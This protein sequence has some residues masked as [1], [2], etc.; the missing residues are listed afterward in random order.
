[1]ANEMGLT[2]KSGKQLSK[3]CIITMLKNPF[4]YGNML[5][6]EEEYEGNHEPIINKTLFDKVQEALKLRNKPLKRKKDQF[7]FTG[8]IKCGECGC[9]ITAYKKTKN[10]RFKGKTTY[11]YYGCT[12]M[13]DRLRRI[14]CTQT[15]TTL[16]DLKKQFE[17]QVKKIQINDMMKELLLEA[18]AKS[19]EK[20]KELNK[21]GVQEWE[22]MF[23]NADNKMDRL[24]ELYTNQAITVAEFKVRKEE[25]MQDK[26]KAKEHLEAHGD[27]QKAWF[28]YSEKLIITT[29]HVMRI[30]KEG[31]P[32][33]VKM[34]MT[35]I[36][37]NYV[38]ED[39]YCPLPIQRAVQ[40][41]C[42]A[43]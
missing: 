12:H 33:Q 39:R 5:I 38:L 34:L 3:N 13:R 16:H 28:N 18:I 8:F 10:N 25:I 2:G 27:A 35:A 36:G 11:T 40:F 32:E 6:M 41:S 30:F 4:Y 42:T 7:E 31:T 37:K 26:Q 43:R 21:K 9:G 1:M 24:F 29:D 22:N 20:E 23:K 14:P 17:K 19:Y 15:A